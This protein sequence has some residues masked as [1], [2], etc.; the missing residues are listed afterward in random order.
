MQRLALNEIIDKVNAFGRGRPHRVGQARCTTVRHQHEGAG[1]GFAGPPE[2][3]HDAITEAL[4]A[5]ETMSTQALNSTTVQAGI[6]DLLLNHPK[7]WETLREQA[8][9]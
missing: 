3:D 5:H 8:L 2:R 7:L 6:K 4:V 1:R 9:R